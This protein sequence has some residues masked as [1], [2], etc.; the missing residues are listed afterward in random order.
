ML[1]E[2]SFHDGIIL[3]C[4]EVPGEGMKAVL[5]VRCGTYLILACD[6]TFPFAS[7]ALVT[8]TQ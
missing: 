2:C 4:I 5:A 8:M 6:G 7:W 3:D 1:L